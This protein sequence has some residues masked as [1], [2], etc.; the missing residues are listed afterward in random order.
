MLKRNCRLR[1]TIKGRMT[2]VKR[3]VRIRTQVFDDLRNRGR[4]WEL[5]EVTENQTR[6]NQSNIRKKYELSYLNPST[7]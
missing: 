3:I 7:C 6:V 1:D 5:K 4:Y 2:D